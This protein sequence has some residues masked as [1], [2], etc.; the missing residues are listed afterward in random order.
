MQRMQEGLE[1]QG[2]GFRLLEADSGFPLRQNQG[3]G[4]GGGE[5][6]HAQEVSQ[7]G[8]EE[9]VDVSARM[10]GCSPMITVMG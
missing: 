1:R 9:V 5:D 2:L 3:S 7:H 4:K 10:A 8:G 6:G